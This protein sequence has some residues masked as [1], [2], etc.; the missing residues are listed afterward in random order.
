M[1]NALAEH[2]KGQTVKRQMA[3]VQPYCLEP[4]LH[5]SEDHLAEARFIGLKPM[6]PSHQVER[7]GKQAYPTAVVQGGRASLETRPSRFGS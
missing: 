6:K 1:A 5:Q 3:L 2:Q 7:V 4:R